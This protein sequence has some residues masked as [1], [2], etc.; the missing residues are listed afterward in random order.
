MTATPEPAYLRRLLLLLASASFFQGYDLSVLALLLPDIQA[1]Y[2][3]REA[4]LGLARIPIELGLVASLFVARLGD[5]FGRRRLLLLSILGYTAFTALTAAAWDLRSFACFQFGSRVFLGAEVVLAVTLVVEEFPAHRRGRA[6]GVL[7]AW[8]AAGT[9]A[10]AVLMAAGLQ[11]T[12]LGWRA[13]FLVGLVPLAGLSLARRQLRESSRF[14]A[15]RG[16]HDGV[17]D[18]E[19]DVNRRRPTPASPWRPP[20]RRRLVTVGLVHLLRSIPLAGA[21]AWWAY[22]A[23]R[24]RGFTEVEVAVAVLGAFSAGGIAYYLCGRAMDRFGRRPTAMVYLAG[25][26][27]SGVAAF[28]VTGRAWAHVAL[29]GAVGFGL[30]AQPVLSAFSTELFPTEIRGR[31]AAAVRHLFE[32]PGYL[33][34][35]AAVGV[36]GDRASGAIGTIGDV[37]SLLMLVAVPAVWLVRKLPETRGVDLDGQHD[38]EPGVGGWPPR[39]RRRSGD[40]QALGDRGQVGAAAEQGEDEQPARA[41]HV[42]LAFRDGQGAGLALDLEG[43]VHPDRLALADVGPFL[44]QAGDAHPLQLLGRLGGDRLE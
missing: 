27:I 28:Q 20:H 3:A 1:T 12:P 33:L 40:A 31:A 8:E 36:L 16:A 17:H 13:F 39:P 15:V 6:L 38:E 4:V 24:E 37:A 19:H 34:G 11:A 23:E 9:I 21:T 26:I 25:A 2:G 29:V 18:G 5:R 35:P 44:A 41:Q 32:V 7:L 30:G 10:V 22:F 14:L 43:E 42:V